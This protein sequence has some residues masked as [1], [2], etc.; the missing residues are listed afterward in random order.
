MKV[1]MIK[2]IDPPNRVRI[3]LRMNYNRTKIDSKML[4]ETSIN[5]N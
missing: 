1:N 3:D 2:I 5:L 4:Q